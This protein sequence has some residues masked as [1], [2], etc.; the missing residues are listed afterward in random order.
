M[1]YFQ[2]KVDKRNLANMVNVTYTSE[3]VDGKLLDTKVE[4]VGT[5]LCHIAGES[6]EEF[7]QRLAD[8]IRE[9]RI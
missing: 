6:I 3:V 2:E 9:F 7:H 5:F 4:L 1:A 8:V